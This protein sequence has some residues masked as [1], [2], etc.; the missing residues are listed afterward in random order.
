M[1]N[2]LYTITDCDGNIIGQ[3]PSKG[4]EKTCFAIL[5]MNG[6][7]VVNVHLGEDHAYRFALTDDREWVR[8]LL[9]DYA[10]PIVDIDPVSEI[11][12]IRELRADRDV[13]AY[14]I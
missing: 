5:R 10:E 3:M 9:N 14:G 12:R 8:N 2:A 1:N 7:G 4:L 11:E 13:N 6:G